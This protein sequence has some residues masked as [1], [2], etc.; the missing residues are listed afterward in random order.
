MYYSNLDTRLITDNKK[1]WKTV[2]TLFSDKHFSKNKITLVEGDEIISTDTEVAETFKSFFSNVVKNLDIKG[3]EANYS[4][5]PELD[6]ISNIIEKFKHH[7][8]IQKIKENVNVEIKFH[9]STVSES[10]IKDKIN[11]LDKKKPS[12]FNNIPT[13]ILVENSDIISPYITEMYNDSKNK[14]DFP[15]SLKSADITPAHKKDDRSMKNNYRP[16]SVSFPQSLRSLKETCLTKSL[17][18]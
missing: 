7:P 4:E 14:G 1:F 13:R 2:K 8:S 15:S 5:N 11:S 6:V 10:V 3:F 16:L 18:I 17:Y 9:F 12:T